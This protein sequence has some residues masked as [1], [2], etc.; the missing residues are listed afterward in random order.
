MWNKLLPDLYCD[1]VSQIDPADLQKRGIRA[2]LCDI[3]NT[4]VTYDD[5][6]PTPSA[7]AFL[8]R[9]RDAGIAV[10]FLSN[11]DPERVERFNA[12]LGY[13]AVAKSAKPLGRELRRAMTALGTDK[14]S[15]M[16]LGD[17][18]FTDIYA[19]KRLGLYSCLVKPIKDKS[20]WF[21]RFKRALEKPLMKL[22]FRRI[23][24]KNKA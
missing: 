13:Y 11:P 9:M 3:D 17:Q 22:Y 16:V 6:A 2:I 12:S 4:L 8:D 5:P 15:T 18:I 7:S 1:T 24:K 14:N 23:R 10:A 19:G 20:S 21:F